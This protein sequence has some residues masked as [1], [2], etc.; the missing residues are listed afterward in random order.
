MKKLITICTVIVAFDLFATQYSKLSIITASKAVGKWEPIKAWIAA[1]GFED[2][3]N[4][5]SYL[6]DEYPG[7][8][9]ITNAIVQAGIVTSDELG[10]IIFASKDAAVPD[11]ML[12]YVVSN[13]CNTASG[14]VKWH[15]KVVSNLFDTASLKQ[16]QV[17]ADGWTYVRT[18]K[19]VK[20]MPIEEQL[21]AE[22]MKARRKRKRLER[23]AE[24]ERKKA[25][26]IAELQTN[27]V[28]LATALAKKKDYPYELAEMLL[29]NELNK[30]IGT[31][32]VNTIITP[33]K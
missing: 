24:E 4:A 7:Y 31:N 30:L 15:G 22:E 12:A 19:N 14:R 16:T 29:Q 28:E 20:A 3:W 18:F 5:C 23:I 9:V 26:R 17:F 2:E 32:T 27:M 1:A 6:S 11:A 33:Q 25:D 13:E 8:P 21:S 10:R